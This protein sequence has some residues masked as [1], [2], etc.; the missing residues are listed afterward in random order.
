M[1]PLVGF[2]GLVGAGLV[3]LRGPV[4]G[5]E[6]RGR[7]VVGFEGGLGERVRLD[8]RGGVR[9]RVRVDVWSFRGEAERLRGRSGR[10]DGGSSV[11]RWVSRSLWLE[12]DSNTDL[13]VTCVCPYFC[14]ALHISCPSLCLFLHFYVSSRLFLVRGSYREFYLCGLSNESDLFFCLLTST[15]IFDHPGHGAGLYPHVCH[16]HCLCRSCDL[17]GGRPRVVANCFAPTWQ[18]Y[19]CAL[20]VLLGALSSW[21]CMC[22]KTMVRR[23]RRAS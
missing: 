15:Y 22:L 10:R 7:S 14:S 9:V 19:L 12:L 1:V 20:H 16:A 18:S 13:A 8:V 6:G 5:A 4:G 23:A 11:D 3:A 2:E 17:M 21:L